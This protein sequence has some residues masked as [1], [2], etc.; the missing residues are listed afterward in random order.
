MKEQQRFV[1]QRLVAIKKKIK[2]KQKTA[3]SDVQCKY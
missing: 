3:D 1:E 2:K